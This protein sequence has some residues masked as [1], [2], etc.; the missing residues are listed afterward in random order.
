MLICSLSFMAWYGRIQVSDLTRRAFESV[1]SEHNL[2]E[3]DLRVRQKADLAGFIELTATQQTSHV[4]YQ[5]WVGWVRWSREQKPKEREIIKKH[6]ERQAVERERH[7]SEL[8]WIAWVGLSSRRKQAVELGKRKGFLIDTVEK[9]QEG[10]DM[11]WLL[12]LCLQLWSRESLQRCAL[13][14]ETSALRARHCRA[15][16]LAVARL[17]IDAD[18]HLLIASWNLWARMY[19][20]NRTARYRGEWQQLE[21]DLSTSRRRMSR[22]VLARWGDMFEETLL[23][24]L[25]QRWQKAAAL[26]AS[27]RR[28]E[29]LQEDLTSGYTAT[30]KKTRARNAKLHMVQMFHLDES[31]KLNLVQSY[32]CGWAVFSH[33]MVRGNMMQAHQ[34]RSKFADKALQVWAISQEAGMTAAYMQAWHNYIL[35]SKAEQYS[36]DHKNVSS[37]LQGWM[38]S[39]SGMEEHTRRMHENSTDSAFRDLLV[40]VILRWRLETSEALIEKHRAEFVFSHEQTKDRMLANQVE[41]QSERERREAHA[42]HMMKMFLMDQ[43]SAWVKVVWEGW[44]EAVAITREL[45]MRQLFLKQ[46]ETVRKVYAMFGDYSAEN[47]HKQQM[48]ICFLQW[49]RL[50]ADERVAKREIV[51]SGQRRNRSAAICNLLEVWFGCE[52]STALGACFAAWLQCA[53]SSQKTQVSKKVQTLMARVRKRDYGIFAVVFSA[54]FRLVNATIAENA[55]SLRQQTISWRQLSRIQMDY[56]CKSY[57]TEFENYLFYFVWSMWV[58]IVASEQTIR[59]AQQ[60]ETTV[61]RLTTANQRRASAAANVFLQHTVGYWFQ[62]WRDCMMTVIQHR[63]DQKIRETTMVSERRLRAEKL[64]KIT[65]IW[66]QATEVRDVEP[67]FRALLQAVNSGRAAR[68]QAMKVDNSMMIGEN[69]AASHIIALMSTVFTEWQQTMFCS[70]IE[71]QINAAERSKSRALLALMAFT[72][73]GSHDTQL[74]D[75]WKV[76]A[77]YTRECCDERTKTKQT[78]HRPGEI[79]FLCLVRPED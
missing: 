54:W 37:V 8:C 58:V 15:V 52:N 21:I 9:V 57:R 70:R 24:G 63:S 34:R 26:S 2:D 3:R 31:D 20:E 67:F 51:L 11:A 40:M 12:R 64:D 27:E 33:Q 29:A 30:E 19:Q 56:S 55:D 25:W 69:L 59:R 61:S 5:C 79:V 6:I 36:A 23:T 4:L 7:V 74:G 53:C 62:M 68:L 1:Q 48:G 17:S 43:S 60:A 16:G 10:A 42:I 72:G 65:E 45:N 14:F 39:A 66:R 13:F 50:A 75:V 41:F 46:V 35:K 44:R 32:F 71:A 77:R 76:W 47:S 18:A 38:L 49:A 78:N 22:E 73:L 28:M